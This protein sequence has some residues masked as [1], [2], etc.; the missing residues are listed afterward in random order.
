MGFISK[1][2]RI[3]IYMNYNNVGLFKVIFC[4]FDFYG[5]KNL[6]EKCHQHLVVE[7]LCHVF[8]STKNNPQIYISFLGGRALRGSNFTSLG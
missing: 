3:Y 5:V 1:Y 2:I 4:G 7:Y 8:P 6:H